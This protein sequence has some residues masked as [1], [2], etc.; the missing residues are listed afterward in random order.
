MSTENLNTKQ[1][2]T[3]DSVR[4]SYLKIGESDVVNVI[5]RTAHDWQGCGVIS[6]SNIAHL[7]KTSRY[8]VDKHIKTL[9][10]KGL[11]EYK[12]VMIGSEEDYYPPY[13]GYKLS[14]QGEIT[15]SKE[16]KELEERECKLIQE[17]FGV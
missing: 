3:I 17:C 4:R 14:K 6:P 5:M 13:N 7:L 16:L 9:K 15:Y 12:S 1:P 10:N 8:Q 11:L 2:C